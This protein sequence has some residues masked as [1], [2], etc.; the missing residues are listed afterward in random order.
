[1]RASIPF[2][3]SSLRQAAD[4]AGDGHIGAAW[5]IRLAIS[6]WFSATIWLAERHRFDLIV[7][8]LPGWWP[9][10][11]DLQSRALIATRGVTTSTTR[12][13]IGIGIGDVELGAFEGLRNPRTT[14]A[15]LAALTDLR[16][17]HRIEDRLL[18]CDATAP[19]TGIEGEEA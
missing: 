18:T 12:S 11:R 3:R 8:Q 9:S 17:V 14:C 1:M 2:E 15:Y 7:G 10:A 13:S 6:P 16:P 4:E 5:A 19:P